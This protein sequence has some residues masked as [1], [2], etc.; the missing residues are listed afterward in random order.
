M[1]QPLWNQLFTFIFFLKKKRLYIKRQLNVCQSA[2]VIVWV[3]FLHWWQAERRSCNVNIRCDQST[4]NPKQT[5][6]PCW[7]F[8]S[9]G[10]DNARP[11]VNHSA[12]CL[13]C[14]TQRKTPISSSSHLTKKTSAKTT[15]N[16]AKTKR[17]KD[18][19][20]IA[21]VARS[22][23]R[24]SED[25]LGF[26]V[27]R[28]S[29]A[30]PTDLW[31]AR[32]TTEVHYLIQDVWLRESVCVRKQGSMR[33]SRFASVCHDR[34]DW[35]GRVGQLIKHTVLREYLINSTPRKA[36]SYIQCFECLRLIWISF[37]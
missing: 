10:C 26:F 20:M 24:P 30:T 29:L 15:H 21:V 3:S 8:S 27:Y 1:S 5:A 23:S 12:V 31:E 34:N 37:Y 11:R 36:A 35:S 7:A 28:R 13:F 19:Q 17:E 25:G 32:R 2:L 33:F 16:K 14:S 6:E 9:F 4:R 18:M 22:H